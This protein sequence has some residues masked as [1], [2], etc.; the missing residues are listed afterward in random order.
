MKKVKVGIIGC[1]M[2]SDIYLKNSIEMF[3]VL[4]IF[5]CADVDMEKAKEKAAQYGIKACSTDELLADPEIEIIV[6]LTVP[7]VHADV[8]MQV[9]TA[10]KNVYSEKP[11]ATKRNSGQEIIAYA[12]EK[13]LLVG[14]APDTFLGG[15]LQT[16]RKMIDDG[17]IGKPFAANAFVM[18]CGPEVFH[19]NPDFFYKEGGGPLLDLGP[20]YLTAMVSML[21]PVKRVTGLA[22]ATYEEKTITGP[23]RTGEK[24]K[25]ET[26]TH[27]TSIMEF[28]SGVVANLTTSFDLHYPY[29]ESKMPY[30]QI[31]GSE[32]TLSVPDPNLFK[33]PVLLRRFG[34]DF[35][36]MP[37]THD[38]VENSRGLGLA[39]MA[40]ALRNGSKHRANVEMAYHVLEIMCGIYEASESGQF[41]NLTSTCERPEPMPQE[42]NI[43]IKL[44][45]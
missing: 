32:G 2:I 10:G 16:A 7:N 39:D 3:D 42:K 41:Y 40:I 11:I 44:G 13:D 21:G 24:V 18:G 9:L 15:G 33:G 35:M 20:Y 1:G 36:E 37:L 12:K 14:C 29:W 28:A 43:K 5:A 25:V 34:G 8:T 26:P 4:D 23:V 38:Y 6:N 27:I 22:K 45:A 17:W 19:P 31:Y 30:I